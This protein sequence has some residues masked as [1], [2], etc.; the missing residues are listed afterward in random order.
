MNTLNHALWG[1]TL[2]RTIGFPV[3][4]AIAGAA[5]D[6]ITL[7]VFGYYSFTK[8]LRPK[9]SPKIIVST[10]RL[11]HNWW[12]GIFLTMT[13]FALTPYWTI[14]GL[15]YFWHIFEDAFTHTKMATPFLFPLWKGKI[16]KYSAGEHKWIQ[17]AE[18]IL[19]IIINFLMSIKMLN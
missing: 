11:L 6:L 9:D 18:I 19:I 8:H 10:Y 17:I 15:C 4:G 12:F 5:P 7:P 3:E 13:I 1:A 14:L 16:Q 2:G